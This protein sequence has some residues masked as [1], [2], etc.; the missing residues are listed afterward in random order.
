VVE[1]YLETP[2]LERIIRKLRV[3]DIVYVTGKIFTARDEAHHRALEYYKKE[4]QLPIKLSGLVMYHCGPIAK[5]INDEWKIVAAGPTTSAR[6]EQF[7]EEFIINFNVRLIVGKGGMGFKTTE[8]SKRLG[9]AYCA[10][11]GGAAVLAAQSIKKVEKVEWLDLGMPEA[12]WLLKVEEFGPLIVSIDSCGN[13]LHAQVMKQ[14][15]TNKKNI[16]ISL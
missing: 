2:T 9:A 10:F 14:V 16:M 4:K 3:G 15:E 8:A 7:E 1:Y 6:M 12:L 13:N 5:K 11:T